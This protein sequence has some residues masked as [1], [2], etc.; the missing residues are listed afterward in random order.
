MSRELLNP[1]THLREPLNWNDLAYEL[2]ILIK[3]TEHVD[4]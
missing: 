2:R 3:L 4:Y 1:W